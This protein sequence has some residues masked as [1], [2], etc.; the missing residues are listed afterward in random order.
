MKCLMCGRK[1]KRENGI[2]LKGRRV[3]TWEVE[4][5]AYLCKGCKGGLTQVNTWRNLEGL[6]LECGY[7][8]EGVA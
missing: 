1:V 8:L 3:T 6:A 5:F 7:K 2:R 4:E